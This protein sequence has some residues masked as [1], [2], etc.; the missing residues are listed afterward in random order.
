MNEQLE[1]E[2]EKMKDNLKEKKTELKLLKEM[3]IVK[4]K[5]ISDLKS[6][7][8]SKRIVELEG[9]YK[10]LERCLNIGYVQDS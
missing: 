4:D 1:D 5:E 2:I 3:I 6:K 10:E 9:K 8:N 7:T